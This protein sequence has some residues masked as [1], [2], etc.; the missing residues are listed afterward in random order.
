MGTSI[1]QFLIV[2]SNG[3]INLLNKSSANVNGYNW[4]QV[5]AMVVVTPNDGATKIIQSQNTSAT[6]I[7]TVDSDIDLKS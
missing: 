4:S 3:G 1:T 5:R 6:S 2:L 7:L